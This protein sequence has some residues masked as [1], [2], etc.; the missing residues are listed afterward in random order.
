LPQRINSFITSNQELRQI[1]GK[2]R[3]LLA[4]QV[5]YEKIVPLSL[6]RSSRVLHI[7]EKILTLAAN[8]S[9]VAAK[10]RQMAPELVT[11][12]Q[13]HGA[14]VTGIQVRVQVTLTPA[15]NIVKNKSVSNR[16]KQQLSELADTLPESPLKSALHRLADTKKT[17]Q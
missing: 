7:E 16:G 13:L 15:V 5:H 17:Q 14:E 10:L 11:Q 2:V 12:L 9:A 6:L 8:N 4:L 1:S 3:Q